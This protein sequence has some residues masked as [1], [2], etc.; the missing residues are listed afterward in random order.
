MID[1][2]IICPVRGAT[3][4]DKETLTRWVTLLESAGYTVHFPPR[5][6][7]QDDRVGWDICQANLAAIKD[8]RAVLVYY[9]PT[10]LGTHFD[11]GMAFALGKPI[12]VLN[13]LPWVEGK[14]FCTVLRA[15]A[16]TTAE[17]ARALWQDK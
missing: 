14:A 11:L 9:T 8:A 2:F 1:F 5:D 15:W 17:R 10:S 4:E 16:V 13:D 7:A 3:K 12:V 6:T